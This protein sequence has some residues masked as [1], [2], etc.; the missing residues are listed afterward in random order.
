MPSHSSSSQ[1]PYHSSRNSLPI[2]PLPNCLPHV[3]KCR[4]PSQHMQA[5]PGIQFQRNG[6]PISLFLCAQFLHPRNQTGK[7]GF[8]IPPHEHCEIAQN[9]RTQYVIFVE[10]RGAYESLHRLQVVKGVG[11]VEEVR[12]G[13]LGHG[14][15]GGR[16]G[17]Y[18][19]NV[20]DG[21]VGEGFK[22]GG[23]HGFESD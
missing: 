19:T 1:P 7:W 14:G 18:D 22:G 21:D 5:P 20:L 17:G 10:G 8:L 9:A 23:L 15:V 13:A 12:V 3:R 16:G 4:Q 2:P 6:N 11:E